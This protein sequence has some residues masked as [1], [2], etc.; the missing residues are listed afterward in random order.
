MTIT[1]QQIGDNQQV[2]ALEEPNGFKVIM[3]K[4]F[5]DSYVKGETPTSIEDVFKRALASLQELGKDKME[6]KD[7][8]QHLEFAIADINYGK[9]D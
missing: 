4:D 3:N 9:K 2:Y 6:Y 7:M 5:Y 1:E 8:I